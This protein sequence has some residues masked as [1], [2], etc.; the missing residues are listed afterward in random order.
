MSESEDSETYNQGDKKGEGKKK[1][2][3][4]VPLDFTRQ[5]VASRNTPEERT[6]MWKC[7]VCGARFYS[8]ED[9]WDHAKSY[10]GG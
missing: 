5:H 2:E 10:H 1:P 9:Y 8:D 6:V 4:T 7:S 3:D